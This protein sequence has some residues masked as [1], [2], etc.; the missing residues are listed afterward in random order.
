LTNTRLPDV[1]L[2]S[3]I[4]PVVFMLMFLYVFGGAIQ[5]ALPPAA[6]GKYIYWLIPGILAQSAVFGS[7]P[8]AYGLH[9]DHA[10][11]ILDRFGRCPWRAPRY[12][13]AAPLPT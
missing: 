2:L 4:Q 10:N 12:W 5:A 6:Q 3:T 13:P 7:A 8:T 9:N 1:L 11:G